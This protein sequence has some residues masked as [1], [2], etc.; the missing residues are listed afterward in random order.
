LEKRIERR[1]SVLTTARRLIAE[2]GYAGVT[3]RDLAREC[4]VT[5]GTLYNRFDS[6]DKLLAQAVEELFRAQITR[7]QQ[8]AACRGLRRVL[9]TAQISANV[10]ADDPKYGR[11]V[12]KGMSASPAGPEATQII[13][14]GFHAM[15]LQGLQEMRGRDELVIW[16]NLGVVAE[17]LHGAVRDVDRMWA[18]SSQSAEWLRRRTLYAICLIL[19]GVSQGAAWDEL[20]TRLSNDPSAGA[21]EDSAQS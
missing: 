5:V 1:A 17:T 14:T 21:I 18:Q 16:A 10:I 19:L 15:Y 12:I 7:V 11:A 2:R 8:D 3:I 20:R 6:K 9:A 4:G 13:S